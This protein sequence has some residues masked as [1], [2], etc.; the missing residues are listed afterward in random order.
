MH[1]YILHFETARHHAKHYMGSTVDL[2]QRL[3]Q[4]AR[5]E[6]AKLTA[7]LAKDDQ[8]WT[9]AALW[10]TA[11]ARLAERIAKSGHC[12]PAWCP[13]CTKT[14]RRLPGGVEIP[15]PRLTSRTLNDDIT[16]LDRKT[17]HRSSNARRD[18]PTNELYSDD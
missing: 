12:G 15:V 14:P 1:V 3:R 5:G 6:G 13:I 2:F 11:D 16:L 4:H 8:H 7:A 18:R 9:V 17:L 10:Q